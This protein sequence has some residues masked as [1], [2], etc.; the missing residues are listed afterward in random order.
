MCTGQIDFWWKKKSRVISK[1]CPKAATA[2]LRSQKHMCF[3]IQK[4]IFQNRASRC[5]EQ[6][7]KFSKIENQNIA[8]YMPFNHPFSRRLERITNMFFSLSILYM[9]F[10]DRIRVS[11]LRN[12]PTL[13]DVSSDSFIFL[14]KISHF[15][16]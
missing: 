9:V 8:F 7:Q 3:C 1:K 15:F 12:S 4:S 14:L 5:L 2:I 13:L 6:S 11:Y 16:F 10:T